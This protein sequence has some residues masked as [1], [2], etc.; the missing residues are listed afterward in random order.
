[1]DAVRALDTGSGMHDPDRPGLR[2]MFIK[3]FDV[4]AN[5]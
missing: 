5:D 3:A 2:E 4:Y 1:M